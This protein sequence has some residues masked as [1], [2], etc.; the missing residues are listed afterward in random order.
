MNIVGFY[1]ENHTGIFLSA[2]ATGIK[3]KAARNAIHIHMVTKDGKSAGHIDDFQF[4]TDMK[5]R[6][7]EN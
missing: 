4:G 1:S 7:P 2:F 5:L 6:L 3:D